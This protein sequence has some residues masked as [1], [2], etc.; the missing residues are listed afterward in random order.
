A[1]CAG[2]GDVEVVAGPGAGDKQ[3]AAFA[4]QVLVVGGGVLGNG[5]DGEGGGDLACLDADDRDGLEFQALHGVHGPGPDGLGRPAA[6][7][8]EGGDDPGLE[9]LLRFG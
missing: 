2:A 5:S 4:L 7:G 1:W 6:G 8:R 9:D 3:D